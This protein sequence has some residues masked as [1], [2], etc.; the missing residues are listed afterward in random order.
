MDKKALSALEYDKISNII[1]SFT[2]S[3]NGKAAILEMQPADT[4][5]D[6]KL[7]LEQTAEADKVMYEYGTFPSFGIDDISDSL[8]LAEKQSMLTMGELL[9]IARVLRVSRVVKNSLL[10]INDNLPH[11]Q[12]RA[13]NIFT[14]NVLEQDIMSAIINENEMSDNA[15]AALSSIRRSIRKANERLRDKLNSYITSPEYSKYLQDN[16]ITQRGERYVIPVKNE[17]RSSIKGLI[18]DQSSS[19]QT[20]Y[21]E[22]I[23]IVEMNNELR[24]LKLNEQKEIERILREFTARIGLDSDNISTNCDIITEFDIIF[25]KAAYSHE[26]K[27]TMPIINSNGY[28]N[29]IK[30]R[31]PLIAKDKVVPISIRLGSDFDILLITGPNTGGKT[32]TLKLTGLLVL[33]ALSGIFIPAGEGSEIS[34][35][36]QIFCDIGDEQSIEQNLST[37]SSHIKNIVEIIENIDKESLVLL[38][39]LGAG[40]DPEEGAS[41]A[42]SITDYLKNCGSKA[43]ITTHYSSLKEYSYATDRIENACMDFNPDTYEPTYKLII[44]VPG[45]SN[46]LEIAKKLGIRPEIIQKARGNLTY[47]KVSFEEVLQSADMTRRKAEDELLKYKK[48]NSEL[49][50]EIKNM[51]QEKNALSVTR[52]KLNV[53]AK[54][55]VKR[56]VDN[57]LVEVN[58]ILDELKDMLD[59]PTDSSYFDAAKL[60][61]RIENI[62][63]EEEE[64]YDIPK[65]SDEPPV[66]GDK[67]YVKTINDCAVIDQITKNGEYIVRIGNI[68]TTVRKKDIKKVVNDYSEKKTTSKKP[69]KS[70]VQLYNKQI[71]REINLLGQ[72]VDEAVYNLS[73][74]IDESALQGVE[75]IKII[76]GIG[77]GKL[78]KGVWEYLNG[79]N[80]MSYR[81]GKYGE[82]SQ[83]VTIVKLK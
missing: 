82:G 17:A 29:I 49:E 1:A 22:P 33:M 30:G 74:F 61:K 71:A 9:K 80:L 28:I 23:A 38:D 6:A 15:S 83:G 7:L 62:N 51:K 46:A 2:V 72:T 11:L 73:K 41:L 54:R 34:Y 16:I 55:E 57:A 56:L 18:H 59:N 58:E 14:A 44:G 10:K 81:E 75:E 60:R 12:E 69:V 42:V 36:S 45:T 64:D 31:H 68:K 8:M 65:T 21:V 37:F 40:T 76:H 70:N 32:V 43:V 53:N 48:L 13:K 4:P 79:A 24:V 47:E 3:S 26:I 52:D 66:E 5:E 50:T 63:V 77:T 20:V 78:K 19:G 35:F 27:G 67:V 39:E 25:A